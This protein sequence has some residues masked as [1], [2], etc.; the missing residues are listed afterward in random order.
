M[1]TEHAR[2]RGT[3]S[4]PDA[5]AVVPAGFAGYF[6]GNVRNDGRTDTDW[7]AMIRENRLDTWS[8]NSK[9]SPTSRPAKVRANRESPSRHTL[10]VT[11]RGRIMS[12][13][14][15]PKVA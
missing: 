8:R 10:L 15:W 9:N 3:L 5:P 4:V 13:A 12:V 7:P 6:L 1:S 2:V 14:D 11:I